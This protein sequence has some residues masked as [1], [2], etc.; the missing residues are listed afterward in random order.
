MSIKEKFKVP[1]CSGEPQ[2]SPLYGMYVCLTVCMYVTY[3]IYVMYVMY[4]TY[5]MYAMYALYVANV[6]QCIVMSCNVT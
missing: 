6:L 3:V 2:A 4:V 1:P 5:V